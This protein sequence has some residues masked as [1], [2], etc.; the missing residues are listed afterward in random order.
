MD[1]E[2]IPDF[3]SAVLDVVDLIP[4]GKVMTYGDVAE[5]LGR[6]GARAV[7]TAMARWGGS[8]AW[9]RVLRAGG[10]PPPGHEERA[11]A[12]YRAEGTP[13]HPSG[14]RV[15]LPRARWQ[16]PEPSP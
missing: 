7:G 13:L 11:L 15:D 10:W 12:H 16:G 2:Q 8:V 4:P 3:S 6:G 9:W 1:V 5:Y 14:L